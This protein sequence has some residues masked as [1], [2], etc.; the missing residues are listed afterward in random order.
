MRSLEEQ[1]DD[2]KHT[3]RSYVVEALNE[4]AEYIRKVTQGTEETQTI[5]GIALD[6][7]PWHEDIGLSLRLHSEYY[8]L[9][10]MR[11]DMAWR[12]NSANWAHF[13]FTDNFEIPSLSGANR[14]IAEIYEQGDGDSEDHGIVSPSPRDFAH[15]IFMAGADALLDTDISTILNNLG[16]DAPDV[17]EDFIPG[18]FDYIVTDPDGSLD[19]NYCD[20]I[21]ANRVMKRLLR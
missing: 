18:P 15:L 10:E 13:G 14:L 6:I 16:I 11:N 19:A 3:I 8:A 4:S 9:G 7:C 12:Y 20:I 21:L 17:D 1:Y 2:C 5:T